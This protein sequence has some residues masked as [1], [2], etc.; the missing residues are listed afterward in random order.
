MQYNLD[1]IDYTL[2]PS[3]NTLTPGYSWH[4]Y[5]GM[6]SWYAASAGN[7]DYAMSSGNAA[8]DIC[9]YG[10]RL[11]IGGNNGEYVSLNTAIGGTLADDGPLRK[12]PNNFIYSGDFNKTAPG[13]RGTFGRYWSSTAE[14]TNNAFRLGFT[15][16]NQGVTPAGSWNKWDAF[17]VR[18]IV[19]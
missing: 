3:W 7:G 18:C 9:P 19:K 5:G 6:Y 16:S 17:A 15:G 14:N 11:P 10:W 4:S 8:G 13:G 2:T 1:N 12:Y